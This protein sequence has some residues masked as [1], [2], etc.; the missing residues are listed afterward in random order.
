VPYFGAPIYVTFN[1]ESEAAANTDL[2][3]AS[4]SICALNLSKGSVRVAQLGHDVPA[5][6][7]A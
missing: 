2:G 1:H 5:G 3:N 6:G 7:A 4:R